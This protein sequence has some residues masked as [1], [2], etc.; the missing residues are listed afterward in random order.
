[1]ASLSQGIIE[2]AQKTAA[3]AIAAKETAQLKAESTWGGIM[4]LAKPAAGF[5]AKAGIGALVSTN[6]YL[7]PLLTGFGTAG[8]SKIF[9]VVGRKIGMGGDPEKIKADSKYGYGKEYAKTVSEGLQKSIEERDPSSKESLIADVVGSYVSA[10][11][12]KIV[13]KTKIDPDTG[14]AI[15]TWG[16]E[17]GELSAQVKE[18][19]GKLK[20]WRKGKKIAKLDKLGQETFA[21]AKPTAADISGDY[22]PTS[23][24]LEGYDD[25]ILEMLLRGESAPDVVQ[26]APDVV[27]KDWVE[28][29]FKHPWW[30]PKEG[31]HEKK[32]R[33]EQGGQVPQYRGGGTIADY[34]GEK[35][36]TLGGSNKQ[37]LAEILKT[38]R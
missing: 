23:E 1:M 2:S 9:D 6:P 12:P 27:K 17:G 16:V 32:Y 29:E 33:Y 24:E 4:A 25:P 8:I 19:V 20:D 7:I 14:E 13:P 35:G 26:S 11:T 36:M 5:L 15:Q 37:S 28:A 30:N 31:L 18:D 38:R 10:L 34:F 21:Y 22:M 3:K